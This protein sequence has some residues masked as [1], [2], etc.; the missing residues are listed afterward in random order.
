MKNRVWQGRQTDYE[1]YA[2]AERRIHEAEVF[3]K[4]H[5]RSVASMQAKRKAYL[6]TIKQKEATDGH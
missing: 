5:D 2:N 3:A 6:T 4:L 1:V